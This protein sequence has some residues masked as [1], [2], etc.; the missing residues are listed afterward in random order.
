MITLV[1][2]QLKALDLKQQQMNEELKATLFYARLTLALTVM[3]LAFLLLNVVFAQ[4]SDRSCSQDVSGAA[5]PF[6][7]KSDQ[8]GSKGEL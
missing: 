7:F 2:F 1:S 6:L 5:A 3:V 8:N 4:N